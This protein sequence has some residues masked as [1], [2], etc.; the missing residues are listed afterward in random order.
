[1]EK[2]FKDCPEFLSSGDLVKLGLYPTTGALYFARRR[3]KSPNFIKIGR[4]I[5]YP[6]HSIIEFLECNMCKGRS[7]DIK[8]NKSNN[9]NCTTHTKLNQKKTKGKIDER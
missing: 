3:G 4:R 9:E 6:K 7:Q 5:V 8:T 2:F 1:M